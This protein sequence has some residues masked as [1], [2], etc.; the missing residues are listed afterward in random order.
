MIQSKEDF[1]QYVA[2]D[3]ARYKVKPNWRHRLYHNENYYLLKFLYLLRKVEYLKNCELG[4]GIWAAL[5]YK[6]YYFRYTRMQNR[7]G[8]Y[9]APNICGPGL[10]LP[11]LGTIYVDYGTIGANCT[12]RPGVYICDNYGVSNPKIINHV[13]GDNVE[14]SLG[15]KI[16]SKKIG[17]NVIVGPNTVVFENIPDNHT[18]FG[19]PA[20]IIPRDI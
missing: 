18:A 20:T 1:N 12:L 11:H 7:Y 4:H 3:Q 17:N 5:K 14:F 16:F 19:N 10:Y 15:C 2:A 6:F 13:I 9:I 8:L